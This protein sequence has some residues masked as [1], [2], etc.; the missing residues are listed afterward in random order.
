MAKLIFLDF[1]GVLRRVTSNPSCFDRDC[2]EHFESALR[3]CDKSKIV[4]SSTWRLVAPLREL[5]KMFSADVAMRIVGVTPENLEEENHTRHAEILEFLAS[6]KLTGL[7]W[8]AID[9]DQS[10][11]PKGIPVLLTDPYKGFDA[12]C[13]VR[14]NQMLRI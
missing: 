9:D 4:I 11:F 14:L 1:D 5:R 12:E 6:R 10:H 2:L 13:A 7:P 3:L 8:L